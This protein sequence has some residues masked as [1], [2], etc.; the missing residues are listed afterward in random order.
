MRAAVMADIHGN[1]AALAA[2]IAHARREGAEAF[3]FLGDYTG[4]MPRP[5]ATMAQLYAL[6][7]EV[8][9]VFIRGNKEERWLTARA[10]GHDWRTGSSATGALRYTFDRLTERD[11]RFFAAMPIAR[12]I[13]LPDLPALTLCHGSPR[14]PDES[15]VPERPHTRTALEAAETPLIFCG[16]THQRGEVI[17]AGRRAVNP[18]AVGIALG[19]GKAEYMLLDGENGAWR[20]R[21]YQIPYDVDLMLSE[22]KSEGLYEAALTWARAAAAVL[23]GG[24]VLPVQVLRRAMAL[25]EA[26]RGSCTWPDLPEK[27]WEQAFEELVGKEAR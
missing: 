15:I 12:K 10:Q 3:W 20:E 23:R 24:S 16:H 25:C 9:C 19:C 1:H 22:L 11:F 21:P 18:G 26:E 14:S 27:Y 7:E 5:Q 4:E 17:H 2:C 13:A 6:A 8:P